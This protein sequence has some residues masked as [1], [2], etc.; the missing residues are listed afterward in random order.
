MSL[1]VTNGERGRTEE[2]HVKMEA[3]IGVMWP[4]AKECQEPP[5]IGRSKG[6]SPKMLLKE[7]GHLDTLT[8][9]F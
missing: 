7:A 5:E 4:Q 1:E 3:E 2:G 6:F 8:S 9:D